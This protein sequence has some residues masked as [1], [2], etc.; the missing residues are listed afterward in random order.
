MPPIPHSVPPSSG[1]E[2][3]IVQRQLHPD[4]IAAC[5][6][7]LVG[8]F[9]F[10]EHFGQEHGGRSR[11]PGRHERLGVMGDEWMCRLGTSR[12]TSGALGVIG[13]WS[14]AGSAGAIALRTVRK[15]GVF[16]SDIAWL[17]KSRR[18][19]PTNPARRR[20]DPAFAHSPPLM[21]FRF[22]LELRGCRPKR[23][24]TAHLCFG[25]RTPSGRGRARAAGNEGETARRNGCGFER[26]ASPEV[27]AG[28]HPGHSVQPLAFRC[29]R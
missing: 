25:R 14:A 22:C 29:K 11:R 15:G 12:R 6:A 27:P 26:T 1:C 13:A 23:R 19:P 4:Q 5:G 2:Q 9:S 24:R 20:S 3:Q 28:L 17:R 16:P 18:E 7:N 10:V 21:L 8:A